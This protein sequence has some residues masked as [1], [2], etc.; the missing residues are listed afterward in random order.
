MSPPSEAP[1]G[2][3]YDIGYQSYD[4]PRLGRTHAVTALIAH[5]LRTTAGIGRGERAK[6][7][8][9]VLVGLALI[10]AVIQAWIG[11]ASG[12]ATVLVGYHSYIQQVDF[13]LLLFCAAQAPELV[14][15]DQQHRVLPLYLSRPL[16]R[17]DYAAGKL[18]ALAI[19]LLVI[20]LLGQTVLFAGRVFVNDDA[21][22]GLR[23]EGSALLPILVTTVAAALLLSSLSLAIAA[24]MRTRTL[25][26]VAII[27]FFLVAAAMAPLLAQALPD[28]AA[29]YMILANPSLALSGTSHWLFDAEPLRR[30]MLAR[31][32]LPGS[33]YAAAA[34]AW[35]AVAAGLLF[36]R[37]QRI[38]A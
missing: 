5:G 25:A 34:A 7:A 23:A 17:A 38:R 32:D 18:A 3:I 27:A 16:R 20:A 4:G 36:A 29:R 31:A 35:T 37:Y 33:A 24:H 26:S 22:A 1:A 6:I 30:S 15:T 19:A 11:A 28:G 12:N 14:T 9:V 10:P 8:P 21:L 13:I 2:T